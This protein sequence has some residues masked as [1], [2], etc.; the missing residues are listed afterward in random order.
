MLPW[1]IIT[2][3]LIWVIFI[4]DRCWSIH[5]LYGTIVEICELLFG[6]L[7]V[8]F[9]SSSFEGILLCFWDEIM[10]QVICRKRFSE[11]RW[12]LTI[13]IL[14]D[15]FNFGTSFFISCCFAPGIQ[16]GYLQCCRILITLRQRTFDAF[17]LQLVP[18]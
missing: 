13:R 10:H 6:Q 12:R 14:H 11:S 8:V 7:L 5:V 17:H 15:F 2:V 3:L 18:L 1:T 16:C 9:I 4:L